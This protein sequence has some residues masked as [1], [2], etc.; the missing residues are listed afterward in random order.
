[1]AEGGEQEAADRRPVLIGAAEVAPHHPGDPVPV[2]QRYRLVEAE[3]PVELGHRLLRGEVAENRTA[4]VARQYLA[5]GEHD[6]AQQKQREDGQAQPL[7]QVALHRASPVAG[8]P[9][10]SAAGIS[11]WSPC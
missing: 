4:R 11:P 7:Y 8:W 2:L 6:D 9:Q 5:R 3:L 1:M 10:A